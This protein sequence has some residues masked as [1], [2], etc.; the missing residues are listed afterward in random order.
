MSL[1]D[2]K[3]KSIDFPDP[4]QSIKVLQTVLSLK[5]KEGSVQ[6]SAIRG[7]RNLRFW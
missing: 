4:T 5:S 3:V 7:N 6:I 1:T 2:C